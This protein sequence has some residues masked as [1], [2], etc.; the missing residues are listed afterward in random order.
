M[1]QLLY[2][3]CLW[4]ISKNKCLLFACLYVYACTHWSVCSYMYRHVFWVSTLNVFTLGPQ[5]PKGIVVTQAVCPSVRPSVSYRT[6]IL[7]MQGQ[8]TLLILVDLD[9][10]FRSPEVILDLGFLWLQH[11]VGLTYQGIIYA[12]LLITW[13]LYT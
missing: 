11:L 7:N 12:K 10:F 4:L 1:S 8:Q 2:L 13:W 6:Y 9:L 5:G 3:C